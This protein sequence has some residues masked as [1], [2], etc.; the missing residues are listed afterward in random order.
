[1]GQLATLRALRH[2]P[3]FSAT[4]AGLDL[5][6]MPPG[7]HTP[8]WEGQAGPSAPSGLPVPGRAH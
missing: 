3:R 2:A 8:A 7:S 5:P 4:P 1:V 6:A